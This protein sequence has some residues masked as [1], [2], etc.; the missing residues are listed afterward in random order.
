MCVPNLLVNLEREQ[1]IQGVFYFC[2][3]YD[4]AQTECGGK[5]ALRHVAQYCGNTG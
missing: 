4:W 3:L 5:S 1:P 2:H